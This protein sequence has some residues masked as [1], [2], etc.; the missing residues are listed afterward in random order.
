ML[1]WA[2]LVGIIFIFVTKLGF[3]GFLIGFI[4]GCVAYRFIMS[5]LETPPLSDEKK[6]FRETLFECLGF[7]FFSK[8]DVTQD[9]RD[10][11][12]IIVNQLRL[13]ESEKAVCEVAF[14]A[15]QRRDYPIKNKL[16]TLYG[17]YRFRLKGR[18]VFLSTLIRAAWNDDKIDPI[19]QQILT[20]I[21]RSLK[22]GVFRLNMMISMLDKSR[23]RNRSRYKDSDGKVVSKKKA[24]EEAY[25]LL[26]MTEESTEDEIKRAYRKLM[27]ENHPDKLIA[28]GVSDAELK[29]AKDKTQSLQNAYDLIRQEKKA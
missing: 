14:L 21:A 15:G 9:D 12:L 27:N 10:F 23:A 18:K 22:L 5:K 13:T 4:V 29:V 6:L 20:V 8:G 25:L 2:I 7:L 28:K 26:G 1:K 24:L 17:K 3:W 19:E 11:M 16:K